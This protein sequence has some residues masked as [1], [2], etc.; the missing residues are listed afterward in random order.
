MK[1]IWSP[2]TSQVSSIGVVRGESRDREGRCN[3]KRGEELHYSVFALYANGKDR[4]D[5]E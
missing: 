3:Q 4:A 5:K 2:G 1:E